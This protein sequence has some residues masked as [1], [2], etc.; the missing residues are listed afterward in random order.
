MILI[1]LGT[2]DKPF[3]RLLKDVL[4]QIELGNIKEEVIAQAGCTKLD[5]DQIKI[6]DLLAVDQYEKFINQADL[7][8]TH[9]GVGTI[10]SSLKL[11][12]KV[13][14]CARLSKYHEHTNDHQLEIIDNFKDEGYILAYNDGDDL[15]EVLNQAIN[16]KPKPLILKDSKVL[17][18]VNS[19][20]ESL[21][22]K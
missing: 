8:I 21:V 11:N 9:G 17:T 20:L 14:A 22:V 5:T 2:Q 10:V 15:A 1:A 13:I 18:I 7:I 16:F 6:Y 3:T 19:Y 4:N 12:K